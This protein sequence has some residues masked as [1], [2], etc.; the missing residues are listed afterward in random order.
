MNISSVRIKKVLAIFTCLTTLILITFICITATNRT[1]HNTNAATV[2]PNHYTATLTYQP[3]HLV[4]TPQETTVY[5]YID[6]A[7][8]DDLFANLTPET[9]YL[10]QLPDDKFAGFPTIELNYGI[11]NK[12]RESAESHPHS[13]YTGV[14]FSIDFRIPEIPTAIQNY[15]LGLPS[16]RNLVLSYIDQGSAETML[17][18]VQTSDQ[19][20]SFTYYIGWHDQINIPTT[21]L[22]SSL[23]IFERDIQKTSVFHISSF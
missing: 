19:S 1:N 10:Y 4:I 18:S 15:T 20:Q 13:H 7:T 22:R 2:I 6:K 23:E 14:C 16:R 17:K 3:L 12:V 21:T 8:L 5:F 11:L 9:C